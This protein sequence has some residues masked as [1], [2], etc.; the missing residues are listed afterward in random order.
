MRSYPR[1]ETVKFRNN[2]SGLHQAALH[3]LNLPRPAF[4]DSSLDRR[5]RLIKECQ[6]GQTTSSDSP[7]S[8]AAPE[9]NARS[10]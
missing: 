2:A 1:Q 10:Q 9:D 5:P 7:T 6:H 3:L 4:L 8:A